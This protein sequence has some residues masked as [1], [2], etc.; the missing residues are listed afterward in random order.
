MTYDP[1]NWLESTF[2]EI[3]AYTEAGFQLAVLDSNNNPA[4]LDF[5]EVVME[6]PGPALDDLGVPLA[7]TVIHFEIDDSGDMPLGFESSPM[8]D[9][10]TDGGV[11]P[12]TVNPQWAGMHVINFDVGVWSSA[13]SGGTTSRMRAKEILYDLFG[14]PSGKINFHA[15]TDGGDGR[16]EILSFT[17]G[18]G[19]RDTIADSP[20]YRLIDSQLVVR[21]Y[22]RTKTVATPGPAIETIDQDPNL[23]VQDNSGLII[24]G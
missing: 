13:Q 17:G 1:E 5:Y 12:D 10:W 22:S 14:A 6:F 16:V 15:F 19:I 21:V 20:V 2:R 18:R 9:N 7:K 11:N 8:V 24:L 3:K 23:E 4:G